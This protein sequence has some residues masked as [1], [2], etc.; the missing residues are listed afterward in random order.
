MFKK[1]L[2]VL[3]A[4]VFV[5]STVGI[6]LALEKGNKR[7]GKYSYRK[8]YKACFER[9]EVNSKTPPI[10]PADKT[11]T[12]WTSIFESKDLRQF[13]C[14]E[15]WGQLS[16]EAMTDIYAYM[17]DHGSDSPTPATCK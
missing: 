6:S 10:S 11:M 5:F 13:G 4:I 2:L 12:E 15:E 17:H 8:V 7:K 3:T 1:I 9:G 14:E 16:D